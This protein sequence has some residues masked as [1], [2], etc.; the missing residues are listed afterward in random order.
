M[1][2]LHQLLG[3]LYRLELQHTHCLLLYLLEKLSGQGKVDIGF[4]KDAADLAQPLLD[5]GFGE[6]A[7]PT[8]LGEDAPEFVGKLVEHAG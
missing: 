4:E 7:P 2:D 1:D 3:R 6:D 8:Q 5:I